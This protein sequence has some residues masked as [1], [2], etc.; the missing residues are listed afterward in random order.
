MRLDRKKIKQLA[1]HCL[2]KTEAGR[3]E[4]LQW[5]E[6]TAPFGD[7][8]NFADKIAEWALSEKPEETTTTKAQKLV[9]ATMHLTL[10]PQRGDRERVIAAAFQHLIDEHREVRGTGRVDKEHQIVSV[11][12]L[13]GLIKE[14]ENL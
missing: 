1:D 6:Y 9:D 13:M 10:R 7:I 4:T 5:G 12:T 3:D 8:C 11:K 14:L 2:F